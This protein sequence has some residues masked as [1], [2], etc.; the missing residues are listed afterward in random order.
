[1][2]SPDD[3]S[4]TTTVK[5]EQ[6]SIKLKFSGPIFK[7]PIKPQIIG[8]IKNTTTDS[9]TKLVSISDRYIDAHEIIPNLFLG[10]YSAGNSLEFV[11]NKNIKF[12]LLH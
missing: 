9:K 4:T 3:H 8:Q 5:T 2:L 7:H 11:K 6:K 1:M 12:K 10:D